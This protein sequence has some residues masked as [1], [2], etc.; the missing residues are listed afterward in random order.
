MT[1]QEL[2]KA[3]DELSYNDLDLLWRHMDERKHQT[4]P[5]QN[6]KPEERIRRLDSA[7]AALRE[8]LT[9]EELVDMTQAMNNEYVEP[10]DED[11]WKD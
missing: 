1:L 9:Q 10:P 5:A 8:G 3:I 6:L 11:Q 7:A 2:I 4:R